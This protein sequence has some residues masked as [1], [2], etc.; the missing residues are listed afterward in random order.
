MQSG[1]PLS[2][3]EMGRPA[4]HFFR[5]SVWNQRHGATEPEPVPSHLTIEIGK[6]ESRHEQNQHYSREH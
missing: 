4:A 5:L 6:K 1:Y 2:L 3:L